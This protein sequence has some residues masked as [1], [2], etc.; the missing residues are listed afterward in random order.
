MFLEWGFVFTHE[1][2]REWESRFALLLAE[3]LRAKRQGQA[4]SSWYVDETYI[5]VN[6]A[7]CYLYRAIDR[8]GNL[9]DSTLS[10]TRDM[11][12]AQR[13]FRQARVVA[14]QVPTRVH[15]W[16]YVLSAGDS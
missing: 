2:V 13:F 16:A 6:G 14:G 7:W 15:R 1:V 4:G 9:V 10:A 12:A 11:E 8:D 5:R 3:K